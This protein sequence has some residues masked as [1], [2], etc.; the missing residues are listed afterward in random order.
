MFTNIDRKALGGK[1]IHIC[2]K[3]I[4][5][6]WKALDGKDKNFYLRST[7]EG[8]HFKEAKS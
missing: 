7:V 4:V 3:C 2:N 6:A 8:R 1:E 5:D